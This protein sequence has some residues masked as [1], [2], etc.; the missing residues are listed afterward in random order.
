[1]GYLLGIDVGTSGTKT[2]VCD[3]K[4]KVLGTAVAEHPIS[5]P[6]PGW[7]EQRPED[8]WDA[9]CAATKAVL[10]KAKIK[11]GEIGGVGVLGEMDGG[12]VF[13][14]GGEGVGAGVVWDDQR[15]AGACARSE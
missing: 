2:L 1:M 4:G 6:K 9:V 10:R 14:G 11:A 13:G 5:T 7:S 8:W 3:E 15:G 12:G